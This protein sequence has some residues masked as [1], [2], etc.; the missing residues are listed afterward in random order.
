MSEEIREDVVAALSQQLVHSHRSAAASCEASIDVVAECALKILGI[1]LQPG[2]N[3]W[4]SNM[5]LVSAIK[6]FVEAQLPSL[7][8][9]AN[10]K[11][12]GNPHNF[13]PISQSEVFY[14]LLNSIAQQV[15]QMN[16]AIGPIVG[17][18]NINKSGFIGEDDE[19][20]DMQSP[21]DSN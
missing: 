11:E 2:Q 6:M 4:V 21:L 13:G 10:D 12:S 7:H 20:E 18:E 5:A 3:N 16:E 19:T 8:A 9:L 15:L 14:G 17:E 1:L